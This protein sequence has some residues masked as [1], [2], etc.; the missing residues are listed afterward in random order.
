MGPYLPYSSHDGR[1]GIANAGNIQIV[2]DYVL[3]NILQIDASSLHH[4]DVG[5]KPAAVQMSKQNREDALRPSSDQGRHKKEHSFAFHLHC[6]RLRKTYSLL[7]LNRPAV[8]SLVSSKP[9]E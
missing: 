9:L 1:R 8:L 7:P 4:G 5:L 6:E 2:N 3:R